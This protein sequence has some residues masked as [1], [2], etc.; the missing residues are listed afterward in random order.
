MFKALGTY[1]ARRPRQVPQADS[2]ARSSR[3]VPASLYAGERTRK[4]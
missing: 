3:R 1:I 4:D 2:A